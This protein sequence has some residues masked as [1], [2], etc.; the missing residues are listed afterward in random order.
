M[1]RKP[2]AREIRQL[3]RYRAGLRVGIDF[4]RRIGL[5]AITRDRNPRR[6]AGAE[7]DSGNRRRRDVD[8][9]AHPGETWAGGFVTLR[10]RSRSATPLG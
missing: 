9:I 5:V 3:P 10:R 2:I 8:M 7:H 6:T 1:T 4:S